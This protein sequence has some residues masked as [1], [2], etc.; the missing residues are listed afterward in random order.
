MRENTTGDL[1]LTRQ[2]LPKEFK[3]LPVDKVTLPHFQHLQSERP[4]VP[5]V[6]FLDGRKAYAL[7]N[8]MGET[9]EVSLEFVR[10]R[11]SFLPLVTRGF[12]YNR[13]S[14]YGRHD[15]P[16]WVTF[17]LYH[18]EGGTTGEM[19]MEWCRLG[20]RH[21][22][23]LEAWH[24]RWQVLADFADVVQRLAEYAAAQGDEGASLSPAQFIGILVECGFADL[25]ER[26]SPYAGREAE[27]IKRIR[28]L[29]AELDQLK[30]A[31]S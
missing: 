17:G 16:D 2:D 11:F 7:K 20:D 18:L 31:G 13:E 22:P 12:S 27:R 10:E 9:G 3:K 4:Y 1:L 29:K 5:T 28:Q 30:S 21:V 14:W 25:T 8:R 6:I 26:V 23:K 24:D 15:E 19:R